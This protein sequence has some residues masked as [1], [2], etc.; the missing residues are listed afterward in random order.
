MA[1]EFD[2]MVF[3]HK[4]M[5]AYPAPEELPDA[6]N[7]TVAIIDTGVHGAHPQLAG[8]IDENARIDLVSSISGLSGMPMPQ[9]LPF[10]DSI[11]S[12]LALNETHREAIAEVIA[13]V[14]RRKVTRNPAALAAQDYSSH[15]TACAGLIAAKARNGA[16]ADSPSL[17]DYLEQR[18]SGIAPGC[19]IVSI[20]TSMSPR[21]EPLILALLYCVHLNVDLIHLPRGVNERWIIETTPDFPVS[22]DNKRLYSYLMDDWQY[23]QT[24]GHAL[25]ALFVAVS[26]RIPIVCAAGNS[27][28]SRVTYPASL[29]EDDNGIISVGAVTREGYR[30]GYSNYGEKLDL[31]APSDDS[32]VLNRNQIRINGIEPSYKRHNYAAYGPAIAMVPFCAERV[33]TIDVPGRPGYVGL[34][35]ISEDDVDPL[36][37]W[38]DQLGGDFTLFGGTSAASAIAAG[39]AALAIAVGK[40]KGKVCDG[41][42]VKRILKET[43]VQEF[44]DVRSGSRKRLIPDRMNEEAR[45]DPP[46]VFG[47]G[48]INVGKA[49]ALA[50]DAA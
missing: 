42:S 19:R 27:G 12:G 25:Q 28:E 21:E 34:T 46:F 18:Y 20:N 23:R 1:Q 38:L 14:K 17:N 11:L 36:R 16:L 32:E 13:E 15:G 31:V 45:A 37:N 24:M 49:V 43:C 33:V 35:K 6:S 47:N 40:R 22:P 30:S 29:S 48:L 39:A 41:I 7:V 44:D 8:V 5:I 10:D 26:T 9:E 3:W 50:G 4:A 2:K